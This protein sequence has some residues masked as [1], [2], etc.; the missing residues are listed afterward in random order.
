MR[1]RIEI[2]RLA[3]SALAV[4]AIGMAGSASAGS[5][6]TGALLIG[7]GAFVDETTFSGFPGTGETEQRSDGVAG[8][9]ITFGYRFDDI[10][11]R[12]ELEGHYR[13]RFDHDVLSVGAP[14]IGYG[15]NLATYAALVNVMIEG[16][17]SSPFTP[18]MGV[19]FGW[20]HNRSDTERAV[21]GS[22]VSITNSNGVDNFA[23]GA[24]LGLDWRFAERWVA[25]A[26]YRYID[27]GSTDTGTFP[28]GESIRNDD[29]IG[30]DLMLGLR[31]RFN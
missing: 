26:S 23:W 15:T 30:H 4:L 27:L 11:L 12:V 13:H 31:F 8:G 24:L 22:G 17:N 19:S 25:T 7:S 14:T 16:R 21:N 2:A 20:A 1:R 10:P 9:G 29:Y 3:G 28:T 6:Y 5:F 18:F